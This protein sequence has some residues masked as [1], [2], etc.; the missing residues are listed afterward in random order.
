MSFAG[1]AKK[2]STLGEGGGP[3]GLEGEQVVAALG[4]DGVGDGGLR[5]HCIDG[6]QRAGQFRGARAAAG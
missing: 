2:R 3:V 5:S 4:D 6:D 1:S